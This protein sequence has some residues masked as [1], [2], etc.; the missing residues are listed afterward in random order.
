MYELKIAPDAIP[1]NPPF[2]TFHHF[3]G[4][5]KYVLMTCTS[6]KLVEGGVTISKQSYDYLTSLPFDNELKEILLQ[7]TA[8]WRCWE[9]TITLLPRYLDWRN[10]THGEYTI[11]DESAMEGWRD[12]EGAPKEKEA[13]NTKI[14][15]A[16]L[17]ALGLPSDNPKMDTLLRFCKKHPAVTFIV[18]KNGF[19]AL[20]EV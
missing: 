15:D 17:E 14:I 4:D 12:M 10:G 18:D 13:I 6:S 11:V 19:R 8:S 5:G 1:F 9:G 3:Q 7:N 2:K 20:K 16:K